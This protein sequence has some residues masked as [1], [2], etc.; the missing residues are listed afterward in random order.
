[1]ST[2]EQQLRIV[3]FTAVPPARLSHFLRRLASDLPNVQVAGVL[4]ESERP[5]MARKDR[6]KR[7]GSLV[8]DPT[9][10]RYA[11]WKVGQQVH[12][13]PQ[14]LL[15][16]G[17]R[18][19]HGVS[20][21]PADT[22]LTA[23]ALKA[24]CERNGIAFNITTDFHRKASLEFVRCL[25][26]GLG[27]I[28]G[29]RILKP[30]L[31]E[32]PARGSINI[33]KHKVP[34]YRG[35]GAPGL[36]ELN[37]GQSEQGITVHRV[38]KEV[39]AGAVLETR[40]FAIDKFDTLES[41]GL[42]ADLVSIDCLIEVIGAE[43][44]DAAVE[45]PQ[46]GEGKVFKGY[47]PHQVWGIER[48]IE[49]SRESYRPRNGRPLIKLAA[50]TLAYPSLAKR[51]RA[52]ARKADYPVVILFHHLITDRPKYMGI[53]T[54]QFLRHVRFLKQHY[55]IASLPDA[56]KMLEDGCVPHPTVV[57][58]FD[59]GYA[60]N[61]LCMRAVTEVEKV[62]V[63]LFVSTLHLSTGEPF[64][65]DLARGEAGFPPL[66]WD[67]VRY[68]DTHG[69]TIA[70]HTRRHFDCG[71]TEDPAV[72]R[73]EIVGSLEDLRRELGHDVP[74]FSFPKGFPAN[75]PEP[76]VC[77]AMETYPW[78]FSACGGMNR[79]PL[80]HGEMLKRCSHP[81]TLLELELTMQSILEL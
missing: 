47:K 48:R 78:V 43:S 66:T 76:A 56:L 64:Q 40:T 39:D 49:R 24:E 71:S 34:E 37:D 12:H 22:P 69:V 29:T 63:T 79:A 32:I 59:D 72:W 70:A 19:A 30:K 4:Y 50:R 13:A 9:F 41:V 17:L 3:I 36:W 54:H 35:G 27:V 26:A 67:Q 28:Y 53:P 81:E 15:S 20:S 73:E 31:F 7:L 21:L 16:K 55:H 51:N 14:R 61:F 75:M 60:D 25:N 57:L 58:T 8:T 46:P 62:P 44:R 52:H 80:V 42:K 11:A 38:L 23:D 45:T 33:H 5:P 10:L 1:M 65:H 74:Y 68:L 18:A 2:T 6:V 77:L